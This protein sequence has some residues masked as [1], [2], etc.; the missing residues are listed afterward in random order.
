MVRITNLMLFIYSN[1]NEK[2]SPKHTRPKTHT[3]VQV[4]LNDE[5]SSV[6]ISQ[7]GEE[8]Y[9]SSST[10]IDDDSD[11]MESIDEALPPK[12]NVN[13]TKQTHSLAHYNNRRGIGAR[14]G[15]INRI[16][17]EVKESSESPAMIY[18]D[19]DDIDEIVPF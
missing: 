11:T 19:E 5:S 18:V 15:C 9:Y 6:I 13:K 1:S 7:T 14:V 16:G 2:R 4:D 12:M 3:I 10:E 17:I 8:N